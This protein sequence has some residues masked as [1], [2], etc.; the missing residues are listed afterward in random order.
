MIRIEKYEVGCWYFN[1]LKN[2]S[3][4]K[5]IGYYDTGAIIDKDICKEV[6][7][8]DGSSRLISGR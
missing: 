5:R 7:G 1:S 2:R 6:R 8:G 4:K 3:E